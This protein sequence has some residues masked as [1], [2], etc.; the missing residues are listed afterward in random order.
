[1]AYRE[2][3]AEIRVEHP[4]WP[5]G[6][7][8]SAFGVWGLGFRVCVSG[9][10]NGAPMWGNPR[11]SWFSRLGPTLSRGLRL[12]LFRVSVG[13]SADALRV[14]RFLRFPA[15]VHA[16]NHLHGPLASGTRDNPP[17]ANSP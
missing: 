14:L 12:W 13:L 7:R 9:L 10:P 1:M 4:K 8:A 3:D 17:Y 2:E 16:P 15:A 11:F 5:L 6:S